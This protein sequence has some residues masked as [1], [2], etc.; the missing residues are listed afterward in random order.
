[1][2]NNS[3]ISDIVTTFRKA[4]IELNPGASK[5]AIEKLSKELDFEFPADFIELYTQV[6]GFKDFDWTEGM[7]SV[8]PLSRIREEFNES[9]KKDFIPFCDY[10]INSHHLGFNRT[11]KEITL[12]YFLPDSQ[13]VEVADSFLACMV[14]VINDSE[15][16]N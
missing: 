1:M 12:R 5:T 16:V 13:D 15:K 7:F 10:L 4:G 14:E 9:V 11:T 3:T 2:D 8:F 6:D